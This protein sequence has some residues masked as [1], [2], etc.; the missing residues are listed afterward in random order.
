MDNFIRSVDGSQSLREEFLDTLYAAIVYSLNSCL[1]M[2][3]VGFMNSLFVSLN[4]EI[5]TVVWETGIL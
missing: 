4:I 3:L 2:N 5:F 1:T